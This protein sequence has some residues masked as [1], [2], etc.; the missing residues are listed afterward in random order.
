MAAR[1]GLPIVGVPETP[2]ATRVSPD[3][4]APD[5]ATALESLE[6]AA[7]HHG[8]DR[9]EV[10]GVAESQPFGSRRADLA[11]IDTFARG[12]RPYVRVRREDGVLIK[13]PMEVFQL[14]NTGLD[15]LQRALDGESIH[16]IIQSLRLTHDQDRLYAIHTF[17]CDIRDLLGDRIGDGRARPTT[18]VTRFAGSFTRYPVLSEV[19]VTYRCNMAC[20]FCYAGCGTK[21][22][23]PGNA[24]RERHRGQWR[25]WRETTWWEKRHPRRDPIKDEMS[26]DEV[27][28]VVDRIAVDGKVP[29]ISFT[30]GECTLRPELPMFIRRARDRGMRVNIITNG[31]L[32][33]ER[34]Y[35]DRLVDAGLTSAQV[36]LS[37]PNATIHDKLAQ[38]TGAFDKTI[39]GIRNLHD[40]GLHVHTNTTI[41][42]QNAN[43]LAG[44]I[45]LAD[46]LDLPHVS[47]NQLIP[48]GT[49]NLPRHQG[50]RIRYCEIGRHVLLA[51]AHAE[52]IGMR[53]HWYS[54]TPFCIFNPIAH[55]LGN[56]GC[57]ACDGLLHVAPSGEVLPCSSFAR[58]VGNLLEQTFTDVWFGK[59]ALYYKQKRQAHSIC[60]H[61]EHFLLCQGACTLYWSG[62]GYA[63]LIDANRRAR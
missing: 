5:I 42:Q 10:P 11:W 22:V 27:L 24:P 26:A 62:M 12:I 55:G 54:P 8:L 44:I 25:R 36:S 20:A 31:V 47:M 1:P 21:D 2:R 61:C 50:L 16:A 37:G 58:G 60:R 49:P 51:K 28:R 45:D 40:A 38:H 7:P 53:F 29:S 6:D 17:F 52:R 39:R 9:A 33:G 23:A 48:T 30:G 57:A 56:K 13:L 19:A 59:D 18:H 41:N 15:L 4:F 14:N 3:R 46:A 35:V 34:S 43:Y 32:C 63:E